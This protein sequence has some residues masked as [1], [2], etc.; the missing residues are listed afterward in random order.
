MTTYQR[1]GFSATTLRKLKI[2][3]RKCRE[4]SVRYSAKVSASLPFN[5]EMTLSLSLSIATRYG[6]E[7]G[8]WNPGGGYIFRA[9]LDLPWRPTSLLYK[10][11]RVSFPGVKRPGRD[12][13][14][15]PLSSKM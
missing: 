8:G 6:L 1:S 14:H 3:Q 4:D 12:V 9:R 11:Y 10:W 7:F 2:S 13:D 15:P 5:H